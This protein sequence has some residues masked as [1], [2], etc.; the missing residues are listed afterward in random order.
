[1]IGILDGFGNREYNVDGGTVARASRI[2]VV[3]AATTFRS[4]NP[5]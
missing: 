2:V 5:E 4:H 3:I 1:M